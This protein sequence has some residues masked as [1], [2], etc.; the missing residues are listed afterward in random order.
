VLGVLTAADILHRASEP[1]SGR[2]ADAG[3]E[4]AP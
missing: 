4:A 2:P 1:G 3:V